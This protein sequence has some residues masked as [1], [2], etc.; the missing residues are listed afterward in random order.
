MSK[1]QATKMK[2]EGMTKGILDINLDWPVY[3]NPTGYSGGW[4]HG[5]RIEMKFGRNKLTPEQEN[6]KALFEEAG[7]K[8]AACYSAAEAVRAVFE[9]LPFEEKDYQG[10]R[11][12]LC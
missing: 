7:F 12:F 2:A 11:E 8:V 4:I 10:A 5:L 1:A 6:K 3:N 9:Y